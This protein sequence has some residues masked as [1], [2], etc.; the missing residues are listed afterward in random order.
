MRFVYSLQ[1]PPTPDSSDSEDVSSDESS[2]SK[3]INRSSRRIRAGK[4][5]MSIQTNQLLNIGEDYGC[6]W[7]PSESNGASRPSN[8]K[9]RFFQSAARWDDRMQRVLVSS[10]GLAYPRAN[11]AEVMEMGGKDI[12]G[13][14]EPEEEMD[15]DE[16][17][18]ES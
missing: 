16:E 13:A 2:S 17:D 8:A 12:D 9:R 1:E 5:R 10:E 6:G 15:V 7:H 14:S 3:R 11:I 18:V 4:Q